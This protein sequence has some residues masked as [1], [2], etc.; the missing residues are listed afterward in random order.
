MESEFR[1][2]LDKHLFLLTTMSSNELVGMIA[3]IISTIIALGAVLWSGIRGAGKFA[4]MEMKL[5][6]E[7]NS[8]KEKYSIIDTDNSELTAELKGIR[9]ELRTINNLDYSIRVMSDRLGK[10]ESNY[11]KIL[12]VLYELKTGQLENRENRAGK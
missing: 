2:I 6:M 8:L 11:D 7:I 1:T 4:A 5:Q 10:V 9:D 12:D 3:T